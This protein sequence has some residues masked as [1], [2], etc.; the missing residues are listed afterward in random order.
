M[1]IHKNK[2]IRVPKRKKNLKS[3]LKSNLKSTS[4]IS[5]QFHPIL[6]PDYRI[7]LVAVV[8]TYKD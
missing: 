4:A 6:V 8:C 1:A 7:I 3:K 2:E 5:I